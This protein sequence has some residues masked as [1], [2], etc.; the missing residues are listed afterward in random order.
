M[1]NERRVRIMTKAAI[2]ED[3]KGKKALPMVGYYRSDYMFIQMLKGF[4][5]G[6][7]AFF[8][9]TA[10]VV[11]AGLDTVVE[12]IGTIDPMETGMAVI[13]AYILFM[14]VYMSICY[15]RSSIQYKKNEKAVKSYEKTLKQLE[16]I[17]G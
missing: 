13:G 15:V 4:F 12:K 2:F 11:F 6:T 3:S 9:L 8:L 17:Y 10:L 16:N 7:I 1:V 14:L 5:W